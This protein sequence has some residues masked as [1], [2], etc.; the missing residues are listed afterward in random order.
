MSS[1]EPSAPQK[2]L[3][4]S[5][6]N[7]NRPRDGFTDNATVFGKI[8]RG[9]LP[10]HVLHEDED[11]LCFRDIA[12]VSDFHVLVIPKRLI[13]HCGCVET[14]NVPLLQHMETV[15]LQVLQTQH[16][17]LDVGAARAANEISLGYHKWPFITV[18]HLHLHCIY[19]MPAPWY[20]PISRLLA[21]PQEYGRFF[22]SSTSVIEETQAAA[23][24]AGS[25]S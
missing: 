23:A 22:H 20:Y 14:S 7:N 8:L 4:K 24:H 6:T 25:N 16:P 17:S 1:G 15:A 11:V 18:H 3:G 2:C 9:E 21:F 13:A 10:A 5:R 12:P 19:P